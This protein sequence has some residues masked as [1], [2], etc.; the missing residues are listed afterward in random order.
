MST[1]DVSK[2]RASKNSDKNARRGR[3]GRSA[4]IQR[5]SA[6]MIATEHLRN[7]IIRRRLHPGQKI[8]QEKTSRELGISRVPVREALKRLETEGWVLSN[9]GRGFI[10]KQITLDDVYEIHVIN[11]A[12]EGLAAREAASVTNKEGLSEAGKLLER[13]KNV[14]RL[15]EWY[16]LNEKFHLFVYRQTGMDRLLELI[17]RFRM[18]TSRII[19]LYLSKSLNFEKA[20]KEHEKIFRAVMEGRS[21]EAERFT[22]KHLTDTRKDVMSMLEKLS[23]VQEYF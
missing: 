20:N 6:E 4:V 5:A 18:T 3:K 11:T 16:D 1:N 7:A 12:L 2:V 9:H 23:H 22:I 21:E 19:F 17:K 15:Q 8:V 13:M 10:V 14:S